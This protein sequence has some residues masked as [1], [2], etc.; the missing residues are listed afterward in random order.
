MAYGMAV[1]TTKVG[2]IPEVVKDGYNGYLV[3]QGNIE[4]I[5]TSIKKLILDSD[6]ISRMGK[7]NIGEVGSKY[8]LNTLRELLTCLYSGLLDSIRV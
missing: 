1:I 7:A 2:A 4:E 8:S 5:Y 3:Q 6:S